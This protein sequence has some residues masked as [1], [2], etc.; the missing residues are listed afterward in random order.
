MS[1]YLVTSPRHRRRVKMPPRRTTAEPVTVQVSDEAGISSADV[2]TDGPDPVVPPQDVLDDWARFSQ[3][4]GDAARVLNEEVRTGPRFEEK[5]PTTPAD[6]PKAG[7]PTLDEWQDFFARVVFLT[8]AEW[9][10]QWCFRGVPEDIVSDEDLQ[11]CILTKEERK[12]IAL[13]LSELANKSSTA[14]RHGRQVI[15]FFET[16]E[17]FILIGMW[18]AKV[19]RIAGKYR[20]KREKPAK[21]VKPHERVH[22]DEADSGRGGTG[23]VVYPDV[24]V[25]NPGVG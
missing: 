15:A 8:L 14:R 19:H 23:G 11:R 12:A 10:V 1:L 21:A 18:A 7:P 25:F 16:A 22:T 17:S 24:Q 9:Y 6:K 3:P 5:P 2:Y 20:P 13:P 4:N